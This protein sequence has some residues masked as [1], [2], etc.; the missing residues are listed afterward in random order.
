MSAVDTTATP[1]A[2]PESSSVQT[3]PA[4]ATTIQQQGAGTAVD[5]SAKGKVVPKHGSEFAALDRRRKAVERAEQEFK[6]RQTEFERR[7]SS[8]PQFDKADTLEVLEQIAKARGVDPDAL[9]KEYIT[10]KTGGPA[11]AAALASATDPAIIAIREQMR[12]DAEEKAALKKQ[13]DERDAREEARRQAEAAEKGRAA[14][15]DSS[16]AV[17]AEDSDYPF[18]WDSAEDLASDVEKACND[19]LFAYFKQYNTKPL[20]ADVVEMVRDMPKELLKKRLESH[21]GKR[22]AELRQRAAIPPPPAPVPGFKPPLRKSPDAKPKE[23]SIVTRMDNDRRLEE[24]MSRWPKGVPLPGQQ[25]IQ[26]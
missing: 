8:V 13:L 22:V 17:Y 11:P 23:P 15:L 3:T 26:E 25:K 10:R 19:E 1:S 5:D 9:I 12:K 20:Y 6:A 18:F 24:A 2:T 7:Q 4:D 14:C 16:K 21:A